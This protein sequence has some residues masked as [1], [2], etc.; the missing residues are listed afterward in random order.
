MFIVKA[1][2]PFKL[3][4]LFSPREKRQ[5][6]V[7]TGP[8]LI[9]YHASA[10]V[11]QGEVIKV[12]N[13]GYENMAT[14]YIVD[15]GGR[16]LYIVDEPKV[17]E[18]VRNVYGLI[19]EH[20]SYSL[21]PAEVSN[22]E[23]YVKNLVWEAAEELGVIDIVEQHIKTLNYYIM[24]DVIGYG[25]I[26]VPMRDPLVEE[27]SMEG[28]GIPVAV[29]HREISDY[30]W[31]DTNIVIPSEEE[32]TLF[33]Q[34]LAQKCGKYISTAFPILEARSPEGHRIALALGEVS[35][36]GSSFTIRKF[37]E[38]PLT[39]TQLIDYGTLSPLMAAYF[40]ILLENLAFILIIGGMA[41]GKSLVE[42]TYVIVMIDNYT[43]LLKLGEVWNELVK[44]GLKP[45][46]KDNMEFIDLA[47]VDI[48]VLTLTDRGIRWVKPRYIIRHR[49]REKV[50]CIRT[51]TGREICVTKD[52]S[53]LRW[54]VKRDWSIQTEVVTPSGVKIGDYVPYLRH[55]MLLENLRVPKY[56]LDPRFGYLLGFFIAEGATSN[57][58]LYQK[59]GESL[60]KVLSYIE[61]LK[62]PYSISI[63]KRTPC[64]RIIYIKGWAKKILE[65]VIGYAKASTK[66]VPDLF[67]NMPFEW[68]IAFLAGIIDCDGS[69][70][71]GRYVI[72]ITTA[73]KDLAYVLL[74]AFASVNVHAYMREKRVRKYFDRIYYRIFIPIG[75][76][77][78]V[79]KPIL[80]W[81]TEEK[82]QRILK[83]IEKSSNHHS[84]TDVVPME[85][86]Y[87]IGSKLKWLKHGRDERRSLELRSYKYRGENTS[88]YRL[89]KLL[90]DKLYEFL[91]RCVGF[92]EVIK[93]VETE[94]DGYVYD[95]EV[96][97]TENFEA[98]GI[99]VHN[100]TTLQALLTL[101]PPDFKYVTI[102]DTPELRLPHTHW[103]PLYTRK[104]YTIGSSQLDIDLFEL[105]KFSL[106][107]R[108]Q[109]IVIGEVRG[110]EIQT[111]VQAAA[112]GQGSMCTFHANSIEEAFMRMTSPPLDV[113]PAFLMLIWAIVL[114][115]RV[116][117]RDRRVVRRMTRVWE[118]T[119][120]D[121]E[122]NKPIPL[123]YTEVFTW[124]PF[125]DS[126]NPTLPEEVFERSYRLKQVA[127]ANGL[128]EGEI[129]EELRA[130]AK[131]IEDMVKEHVFDYNMVS[132]RLFEFYRRK[133]LT[134]SP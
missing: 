24:R 61:A 85:I 37:P 78:E 41:S 69:I 115:R 131:Y 101:G 113:K 48:K 7:R 133:R 87:A 64:I 47:N 91:P 30:T 93:I 46:R 111:L 36:R 97:E 40:W 39:I 76:N 56:L 123:N 18:E 44:R 54:S 20:L 126:F 83:A 124:D 3:R 35:G 42:D 45:L 70:H 57:W 132:K 104:G 27:I 130:R 33:V 62:I 17:P 21:K 82:K 50:V 23:D 74:Y 92:D 15:E 10:Y 9:S 95:F 128:T 120:L 117:L 110:K 4:L 67:W 106:R 109:Y 25:Y 114:M 118:V 72:E 28:P 94:Y 100:T 112:T 107:R 32:A 108:G 81:L 116:R 65:H 84:E 75:I 51:K 14:V 63:D 19:M 2:L 52:H 125:T 105:T 55:L 86:A 31:L 73:S 1:K 127:E 103:D 89:E 6:I 88:F 129:I 90:G 58:S 60:N 68:R 98:N 102:E 22:V 49:V 66:R 13:T 121:L 79:L 8:R 99:F 12:Y 26:D 29:V 34:K 119:G 53:L 122:S 77:S 16:G 134:Y 38:K 59:H 80:N 5:Q 96:P 43:R 11:T 71:P